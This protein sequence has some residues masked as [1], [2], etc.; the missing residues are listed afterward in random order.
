MECNSAIKFAYCPREEILILTPLS[1]S[2]MVV[3][4][5]IMQLVHALQH[6]A[7]RAPFTNIGDDQMVAIHQLSNISPHSTKEAETPGTNKNWSIQI[8]PSMSLKT[9]RAVSPVIVIQTL[10]PPSPKMITKQNEP[11]TPS[12]RNVIDDNNGLT[13]VIMHCTRTGERIVPLDDT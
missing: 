9:T 8:P 4:C 6:P 7:P 1:S 12:H 13:P 5:R 11:S 2:H 3:H 10:D